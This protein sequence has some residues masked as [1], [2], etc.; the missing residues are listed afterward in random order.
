MP[1]LSD[2]GNIERKLAFNQKGYDSTWVKRDFVTI[3]EK[4][5]LDFSIC[6]V[7]YLLCFKYFVHSSRSPRQMQEGKKTI[8]LIGVLSLCPYLLIRL[9]FVDIN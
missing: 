2:T 3:I 9:V 6:Y 5:S 8:E 1:F 7:Q 4:W